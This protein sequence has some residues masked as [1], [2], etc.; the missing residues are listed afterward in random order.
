MVQSY[1]DAHTV[2]PHKMTDGDHIRF[3]P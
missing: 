1:V 2:C 3:N